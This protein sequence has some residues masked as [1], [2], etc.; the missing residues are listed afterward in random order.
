MQKISTLTGIIIIV[1]VAVVAFGSVFAYQYFTKIKTANLPVQIQQASTDL[2]GKYY[3]KGANNIV[4][5]EINVSALNQNKIELAGNATWENVVTGGA[6]EGSFKNIL[7]VANNR[8]QYKD[9]NCIVNFKFE[10]NRIIAD[11]KSELG[12]W[13]MNVSFSGDYI[14]AK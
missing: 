8:A 4:N 6:N 13:G 10:I 3:R 9:G 11:D 2:S 1:A 14:K 12:C 5:G 7:S